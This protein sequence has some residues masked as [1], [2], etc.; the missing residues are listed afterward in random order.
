MKYWDSSAIVPLIVAEENTDYCLGVLSA[1]PEMLIWCLSRV[2]VIS[3]LCRRVREE[4][5]SEDEF[6]KVKQRLKIIKEN[7][8]TWASMPGAVMPPSVNCRKG[9][10][11]RLY[12]IRAGAEL[13][14]WRSVPSV[15]CAGEWKGDRTGCRSAG[16]R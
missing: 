10:L 13:S 5:L 4:R 11:R 12:R 2:E 15:V 14:G 7:H 3:A 6:Q 9:S 16:S 8:R 1:D